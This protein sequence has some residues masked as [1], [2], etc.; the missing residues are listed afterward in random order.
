M[1]RYPLRD[2][3]RAAAEL[4]LLE[5]AIRDNDVAQADPLYQHI[6][7]ESGANQNLGVAAHALFTEI[8]LEREAAGRRLRDDPARREM[9]RLVSL[10]T[11]PRWEDYPPEKRGRGRPK[12]RD[13]R[14]VCRKAMRRIRRDIVQVN[15]LPRLGAAA[16]RAK[17][18]AAH[19]KLQRARAQ[20]PRRP[21]RPENDPREV[22]LRAIV[23]ILRRSPAAS[24][25]RV[26]ELLERRGIKPNARGFAVRVSRA[27]LAIRRAPRKKP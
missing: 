6:L 23:K 3:E 22:E 17:E 5:R 16:R 12:T 19:G 14:D 7:V 11:G 8:A 9:W 2:P 10:D 4:R 15:T 20:L 13:W 21:R 18:G 1:A 24:A 25:N 26:R 27:R